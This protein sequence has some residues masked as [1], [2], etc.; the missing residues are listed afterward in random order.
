[1]RKIGAYFPIEVPGAEA[2]IANGIDDR[3]QM[4][5]EYGAAISNSG[6]SERHGFILNAA[7]GLGHRSDIGPTGNTVL[8]L[9]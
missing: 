5:G 8:Y 3:G 4:A 7:L 9:T 6:V 1:M 2:T